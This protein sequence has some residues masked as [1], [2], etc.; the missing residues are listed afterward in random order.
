LSSKF[1][2]NGIPAL[3]IL[4]RDGQLIT[5]AGRAAV[6]QDPIGANLPWKPKSPLEM[7]ST[8]SI[9]G[10]DGKPKSFAEATQGAEAVGL[11]FSASWCGPCHRFTPILAECY[12]GLAAQDAEA[13]RPKRFEV[14]FLSSDR[15]Q[16]SF[17]KYYADMPWLALDFAQGEI[18]EQLEERYKVEG[19]PTLVVIDPRTGNSLNE[20][21]VAA[22][23]SDPKGE[24][25]P[26]TPKNVEILNAGSASLIGPQ[27]AL[28]VF[29]GSDAKAREFQP[30]LTGAVD[31]WRGKSEDG[32]VCHGDVCIPTGGKL[33][34]TEDILF[35]VAGEHPIVS[36]VQDLAKA[37]GVV[38]AILDLSGPHYAHATEITSLEKATPMAIRKFVQGYLNGTVQKLKV[39]QL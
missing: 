17:N 5:D 26:W 19:I 27:P 34:G 14:I 3:V 25:F 11:Y 15:D 22:V 7:L 39:Q 16:A 9:V 10:K 24:N 31:V 6:M 8:A 30:D 37:K 23:M 33:D 13:K 4:G 36:R 21:T 18:K 12:K 2:V 1:K 29:C 35:F 38:L 20:D 32:A 28:I